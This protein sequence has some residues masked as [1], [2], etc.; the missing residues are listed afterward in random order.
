MSLFE[1]KNQSAKVEKYAFL[2]D[3]HFR[4]YLYAKAAVATRYL[5]VKYA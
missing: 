5:R 2:H 4:P 3:G 1:G